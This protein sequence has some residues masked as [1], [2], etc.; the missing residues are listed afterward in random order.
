MKKEEK[1]NDTNAAESTEGTMVAKGP[2]WPLFSKHPVPLFDGA[3]DENS[4]A[5]YDSQEAS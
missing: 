1:V 5:I 2:K 4:Q 3:G